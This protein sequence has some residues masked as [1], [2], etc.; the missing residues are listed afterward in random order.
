MYTLTHADDVDLPDLILTKYATI[1]EVRVDDSPSILARFRLRFRS[2]SESRI[3]GE[4]AQTLTAPSHVRFCHR[5]LV[6][7]RVDSRGI[8]RSDIKDVDSESILREFLLRRRNN[9]NRRFCFDSR[10]VDS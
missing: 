2:D 6:D 5:F 10:N 8:R 1:G 9:M 7:S 4:S 3:D